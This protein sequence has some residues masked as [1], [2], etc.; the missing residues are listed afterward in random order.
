VPIEQQMSLAAFQVAYIVDFISV[1]ALFRDDV[2][3]RFSWST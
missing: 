1:K 3:I 2:F